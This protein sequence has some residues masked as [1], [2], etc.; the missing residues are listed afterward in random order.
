MELGDLYASTIYFENES[1]TE[2]SRLS[3]EWYH[4]ARDQFYRKATEQGDTSAQIG[5]GRY[6]SQMYMGGPYTERDRETAYFWFYLAYLNG[7]ENGKSWCDSLTASGLSGWLFSD[8]FASKEQIDR[9]M[10]K[11]KQVF[12]EQKSNNS[13]K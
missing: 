2:C 6:Y 7:N 1:E 10:R 5:L 13:K 11:A 8:M 12:E 3:M 9:A 4:K